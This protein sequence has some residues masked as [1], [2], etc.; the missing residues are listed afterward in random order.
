MKW[1]KEYTRSLIGGLLFIFIAGFFAPIVAYIL[2]SAIIGAA[3]RPLMK[4]LAK[5]KIAKK[6]LSSGFRAAI[7][8]LVFISVISLLA[9]ILAPSIISQMSAVREI[10]LDE[11]SMQLDNKLNPVKHVLRERQMVEVNHDFRDNIQENVMKLLEGINLKLMFTNIIG[12][13]GSIFMSLFA[14]LFMSFFFIKEDELFLWILLLFVSD[15][16]QNHISNIM[17]KVRKTLN[18][19]FFGL[20]IEVSSMM[21]LLSVGGLIIGLE[22]A[23][24]IGFLGGLLNVIPYLGPLIGAFIGAVLVLITNI[25]LGVDAAMLMAG[26][27]LIVFAFANMLDNF[28]LQPLI[29]SNSV[30]MHPMAIF[31][32]IFAGG[33]L[34]GPLG[35]ILA[36]PVMTVLRI[37]VGEFFGDDR[38]VKKL[39]RGV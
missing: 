17:K 22:N 8:L 14:I 27:I 25:G 2:I 1:S 32:I 12:V 31:I 7:V 16:N 30:Q 36:I 33:M 6:S 19:Y 10:D 3:G 5:V 23:I 24:L 35:M 39:T 26:Q 13:T 20:L 38:M 37:V 15:R 29:Y 4:L 21:V 11:V 34:G 28:V 18:R 9:T